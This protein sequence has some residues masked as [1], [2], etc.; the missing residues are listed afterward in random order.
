MGTHPIFESDF[1]CL[2]DLSMLSRLATRQ[3]LLVAVSPKCAQMCRLTLVARPIAP[4]HLVQQRQLSV[5]Q[6]LRG[7]PLLEQVLFVLMG[8]F[9][10]MLF[11]QLFLGMGAIGSQP[12]FQQESPAEYAYDKV[13]GMH[14][15]EKILVEETGVQ[16]PEEAKPL[17]KK[18]GANKI[19][20]MSPEE[21][22]KL[23]VQVLLMPKL[24][25][26]E[27]LCPGSDTIPKARDSIYDEVEE[28]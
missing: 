22:E 11:C 13:F 18:Y 2:T 16:T 26:L 12:K 4:T 3:R 9:I 28:E 8:G 17:L 1:D 6:W 27:R 14:P 20:S 10:V 25:E 21:I 24:A 15:V 23:K 7:E 19:S 5:M